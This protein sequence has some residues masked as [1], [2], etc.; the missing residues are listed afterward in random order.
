M[1]IAI[2]IV[3]AILIIAAVFYGYFGGFAK[4]T[5]RTLNQGGEILVYENVTGPYSQSAKVSDRIYY[6]LLDNDGIETTK[7]FGIYYDNPKNTAQDKLRSEVGC[8]IENAD[9]TV[10]EKLREKYQVKQLP[11]ENCAVAE[12]PLRGSFSIMMGIMRVYPAIEKY[13]REH[14]YN[15]GPVMEI[16]DVPEKKIIYRKIITQ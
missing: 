13:M 3:A 4:I 15:D 14:K 10:T 8:I 2:K 12:F 1:K 9:N 6:D 7:G 5:I 16:Y 11:V